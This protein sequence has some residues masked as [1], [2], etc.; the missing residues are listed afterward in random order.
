MKIQ[1]KKYQEDSS[2]PSLPIT[3]SPGIGDSIGDSFLRMT[4]SELSG[5]LPG[6]LPVDIRS[7]GLRTRESGDDD[8]GEC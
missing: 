4:R 5:L 3:L 7:S 6:S 8:I 1:L 2:S